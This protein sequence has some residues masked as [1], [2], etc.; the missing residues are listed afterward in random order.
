VGRRGATDAAA[1]P[2]AEPPRRGCLARVARL[3]LKG[4]ALAVLLGGLYVGTAEVLSHMPG[5]GRPP[6]PDGAYVVHVTTN[7]VHVDLWLPVRTDV[8]D[9]SEWIPPVVPLA[10]RTHASFGW[11][12]RSFYTQV[13]TWSDLTPGV[14][15]RGALLPSPT[16]M[17]VASRSRPRR[18]LLGVDV[19]AIG[20][21]R[22][23]YAALV[24]YVRGSFRLD[25]DGAP[26]LIDHP[27]YTDRDRFFEGRGSYHLFRTCNEWVSD[28]LRAAGIEAPA[29]T[30]F[31]RNVLMGLR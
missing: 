29:W 24:E 17:R 13:P 12:D 21:E 11:G 19:F 22:E 30:P 25:A 3:A 5:G 2:A 8:V 4:L 20:L 1:G 31:E 7:G 6:T 16:A 23:E 18:E 9:W 27:G 15:L 14:A 28:G 10:A 26:L